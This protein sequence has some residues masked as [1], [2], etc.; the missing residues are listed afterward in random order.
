[1]MLS[2][3][4]VQPKPVQRLIWLTMS[5]F[6]TTPTMSPVTTHDDEIGVGLG[7]QVGRFPDRSFCFDHCQTL[8]RARQHF[9]DN[10]FTGPCWF[11]SVV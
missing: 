9:L 1:M 6:V 5:V 10:H 2:T 7:H 3:L 11:A 4:V 8:A